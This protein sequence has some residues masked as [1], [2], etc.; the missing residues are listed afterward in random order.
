MKILMPFIA[1]VAL[2]AALNQDI[3]QG[4]ANI[5]VA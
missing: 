3:A 1:I 5:F 4:L 2:I